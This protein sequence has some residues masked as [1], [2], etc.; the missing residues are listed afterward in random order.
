[1]KKYI[2]TNKAKAAIRARFNALFKTK[3]PAPASKTKIKAVTVKPDNLLRCADDI[4][5]TKEQVL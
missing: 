2:L 1:M 5:D 4:P 3:S